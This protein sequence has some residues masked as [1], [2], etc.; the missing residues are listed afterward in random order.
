M[1]ITRFNNLDYYRVRNQNRCKI[2]TITL[3]ELPMLAF[4]KTPEDNVIDENFIELMK[5][6]T[7]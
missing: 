5:K 4:R 7:D 1:K 2:G 3:S 6:I